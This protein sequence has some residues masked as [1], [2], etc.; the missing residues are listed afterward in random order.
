MSPGPPDD[1]GD[2]SDGR[3]PPDDDADGDDGRG[4]PEF[5]DPPG[6]RELEAFLGESQGRRRQRGWR[7]SIRRGEG[8][9]EL[10]AAR[11]ETSRGGD[12]AEIH[13]D[14]DGPERY[15]TVS[16]RDE[17]DAVRGLE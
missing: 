15:V 10:A 1:E 14:D 6:R 4:P 7:V 3:G 12:L 8:R 16:V 11:I 17:L 9:A 13:I 2:D 5:V